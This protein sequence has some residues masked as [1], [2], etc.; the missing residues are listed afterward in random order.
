MIRTISVVF[1]LSAVAVGAAWLAKTPGAVA[2]DWRGWRLDTTVGVALTV[3]VGFVLIVGL[4][5]RAWVWVRQGLRDIGASRA[6]ERR[7]QGYKALSRGMV[8]VAAGDREESRRLAGR[9]ETLLEDPPLTLLLSAQAAQLDGDEGAAERYFRAMLD[10]PELEFLGVRGL[11]SSA[12]RGSD[13]ERA[14]EYAHRAYRLRPGSGWIQDTLLGLQI[15]SGKWQQAEA[16]LKDMRR[17]RSV[18]AAAA[19]RRGAILWLEQAGRAEEAGDE[20]GAGRLALRAHTAASDFVPAAVAAARLVGAAG[21]RKRAMKVLERAWR[22]APHPALAV[23]L[24]ALWPE[25]DAAR[26]L[27][28]LKRLDSV[29]PGRREGRVALARAAL[30]ANDFDTA[31][32][33]LEAVT[34]EQPEVRVCALWAELEDAE[35][36]PGLAAR[37]WL[38]RAARARP[39]PAWTCSACG[40]AHARWDPA[41]GH[42]E[43]FDSLAWRVLPGPDANSGNGSAAA[44]IAHASLA[45]PSADE[46]LQEE[47]APE[48]E[49][50]P[51]P[52]DTPTVIPEEVSRAS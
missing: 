40:V 6:A 32:A 29:N 12:L 3:V 45:P 5:I 21:K 27:E 22:F 18:P 41:C 13:S 24:R 10:D 39:G 17:R 42:C 37:D 25:D 52:P 46:P 9:A 1:L 28:R 34:G 44:H 36:G 11:L 19:R 31:R 35:N 26:A 48:A 38:M 15:A 2:V 20:S 43:A 51:P 49:I 33:A 23:A 7:R 16:L 30:T 14:L 50:L 4:L 8:A 47:T